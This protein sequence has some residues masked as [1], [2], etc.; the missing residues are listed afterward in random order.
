[1]YNK[2]GNF[3][4]NEHCT[5]AGSNKQGRFGRVAETDIFCSWKLLESILEVSLKA[6]HSKIANLQ[7][8]VNRLVSPFIRNV[9]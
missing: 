6:T 5:T 1:M 3:S 7:Q 9:F 2:T 8:W 4:S